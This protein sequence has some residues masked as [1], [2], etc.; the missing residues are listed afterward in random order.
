MAE[1]EER[2]EEGHRRDRD[3]DQGQKISRDPMRVGRDP[4]IEAL[5]GFEVDHRTDMH[6]RL[7]RIAKSTV[8]SDDASSVLLPML[9]NVLRWEMP[10]IRALFESYGL[11][12]HEWQKA[13]TDRVTVPPGF[14]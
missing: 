6:G 10:D 7:A 13:R 8:L 4:A 2:P 11:T 5:F 12:L 9:E 14:R 1:H 3:A